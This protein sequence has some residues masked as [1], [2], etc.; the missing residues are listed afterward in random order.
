MPDARPVGRRQTRDKT[1]ADAERIDDVVDE[2]SLE[3]FPASDPPAWT[4]IVG[5]HIAP[6]TEPK[7]WRSMRL[8]FWRADREPP[9]DKAV[10]AALWMYAVPLIPGAVIIWVLLTQWDRGAPATQVEHDTPGTIGTS[11]PPLGE[12]E[13]TGLAALFRDA[14]PRLV[15]R[16]I[17]VRNAEVT[18]VTGPTSFSIREGKG[19]A[20]VGVVASPDSEAVHS[21]LRVDVS[22]V[23]ESDA[24][25]GLRIRADAVQHRGGQ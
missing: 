13:L 7:P 9:P 24:A 6:P 14:G 8:N 12:P 4:P 5:V 10:K 11:M 20:T 15:G 25:G 16:R 18:N 22:G 1:E 3:S 19:T 21:G 17:S 2:A 23:V